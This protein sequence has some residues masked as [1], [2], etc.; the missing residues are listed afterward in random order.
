M[1]GW[2]CS[3]CQATF[4]EIGAPLQPCTTV[5]TCTAGAAVL[6]AVRSGAAQLQQ[7]RDRS[8]HG[9]YPGE[10]LSQP[11]MGWQPGFGAQAFVIWVS[12]WPACRTVHMNSIVAEISLALCLLH[13]EC[14]EAP[15]QSYYQTLAPSLP[16]MPRVSKCAAGFRSF[17]TPESYGVAARHMHQSRHQ[18]CS[19]AHSSSSSPDN[20]ACLVTDSSSHAGRGAP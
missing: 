8:G 2:A 20:V 12:L 7:P 5:L 6:Q 1:Q 4:L 18:G 16:A 9:P 17:K 3:P 19:V 14:D 10:L 15:S 11:C 13:V